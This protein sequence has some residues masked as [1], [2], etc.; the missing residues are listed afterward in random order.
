[1]PIRLACLAEG[2][3]VRHLRLAIGR[4]LHGRRV[5]SK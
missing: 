3:T 1:V 5:L 2:L 4:A